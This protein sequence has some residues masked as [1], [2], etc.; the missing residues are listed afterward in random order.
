MHIQLGLYAYRLMDVELAYVPQDTCDADYGGSV[1]LPS[2]MC[3]YD[4]GQDS[5]NR[6]SGGPLYDADNHV[7]VGIVSW[8]ASCAGNNPGVYSRISDQ[9]IW[10][11]ETICENHSFPKPEFCPTLSPSLQPSM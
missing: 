11:R 10:I 6:D 3:A 8:G 5:C 9:W 1:I 7:Q 4:P 2:M